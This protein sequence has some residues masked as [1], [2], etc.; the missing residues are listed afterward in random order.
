MGQVAGEQMQAAA[1][2]PVGPVADGPARLRVAA[3]REHVV[4]A[5]A[6]PLVREGGGGCVK[7][8]LPGGDEFFRRV[9]DRFGFGRSHVEI[10]FEPVG[11][12][13]TGDLHRN[14][15]RIAG[16]PLAGFT[17]DFAEQLEQFRVPRHRGGGVMP[18]GV[19][20][21]GFVN[22]AELLHAFVVEPVRHPAAGQEAE[23]DLLAVVAG[24]F[25]DAVDPAPV[26][27]AL[28]GNERPDAEIECESVDVRQ[29]CGRLNAVDAAA[30]DDGVNA[31]MPRYF[32]RA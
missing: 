22:P 12:R 7:H 29:F 5:P 18:A 28:F 26:I 25:D 21:V 2:F 15:G 27:N 30:A 31:G 1:V 23:V 13:R 19:D 8:G 3:V 24:G 10:G 32:P 6:Q 9:A 17:A 20:E 14:D 4:D 16:I 11:Q